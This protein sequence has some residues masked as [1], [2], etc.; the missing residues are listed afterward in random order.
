[1]LASPSTAYPGDGDPGSRGS[2]IQARFTA[3]SEGPNPPVICGT[4]SGYH[5]ILEARDQCNKLT[6]T[7]NNAVENSWSIQVMQISCSAPWKPAAGCLQYFT[8]TTGTLYSYNYQ[9]SF[10]LT[11]QQYHNCIRTEEGYC[12]ISYST[13]ER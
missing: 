6:V 12:S 13:V 9:E 11:N 4:N 10:H 5:M 3:E 8:G 2:C 1:M 7:W